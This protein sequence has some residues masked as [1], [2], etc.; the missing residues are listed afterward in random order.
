MKEF[1]SRVRQFYRFDNEELKHFIIAVLVC[2][3]IFGFNDKQ[4]VFELGH[5]IVNFIGAIIISGVAIFLHISAQKLW[6]IKVGYEARFKMSPYLLLIGLIV[7]VLSGGRWYFLAPGTIMLTHITSL[8]LGAFRHGYN[9]TLAGYVALAGPIMSVLAGMF[10][11]VIWQIFN[12]TTPF[13]E[14]FI[15]FNFL[16]AFFSML[17]LP[18]LSGLQVFFGSRMWFALGVG[19]VFGYLILF[20]M[21]MY[22]LFGALFI[23]GVIWLL[24]YVTFERKAW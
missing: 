7:S 16:L 24:Y 3:F 18:G 22:S 14:Q 23:G 8:R 5:W 21:N 2:A 10:V 9:Y 20:Y 17:P 15:F 6:G 11:K 19:C 13:L 4:E 1:K 12:F